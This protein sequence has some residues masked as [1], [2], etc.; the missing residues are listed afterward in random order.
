VRWEDE[1]FS[2]PAAEGVTV[3]EVEDDARQ[4]VDVEASSPPMEDCSVS[5]TDAE[6]T[7]VLPSDF[8]VASP[9]S[10]ATC[11]PPLSPASRPKSRTTRTVQPP[12]EDRKHD[13][14]QSTA[15]RRKAFLAP[16]E[17]S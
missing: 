17:A 3:V 11:I 14:K 10:V 6:V 8:N 1:E 5:T 15:R 13:Q 9:A 16:L 7:S 12:Q 2:E 4:V